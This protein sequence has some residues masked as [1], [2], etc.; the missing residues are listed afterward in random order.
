MDNNI[1][2]I[3]IISILVLV[4]F[5]SYFLFF[6]PMAQCISGIKNAA[7]HPVTHSAAKRSCTFILNDN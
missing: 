7:K 3:G 1:K 6:S 2:I 5:F 4:I